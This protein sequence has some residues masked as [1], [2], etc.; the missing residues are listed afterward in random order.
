METTFEYKKEIVWKEGF[1]IMYYITHHTPTHNIYWDNV[2]TQ[3]G[4]YLSF[5]K[6]QEKKSG[7][8]SVYYSG[9]REWGCC[10]DMCDYYGIGKVESVEEDEIE[11]EN[12]T[13]IINEYSINEE[14]V[15][16]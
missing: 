14:C 15:F 3:A 13:Y 9:R 2:Y 5:W 8:V 10:Q 6:I 16:Y 12:D 11:E 4:N 7:K 1:P